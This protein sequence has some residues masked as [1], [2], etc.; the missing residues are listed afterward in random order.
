[1]YTPMAHQL[2]GERFLAN[3]EGFK[4]LHWDMGTGKS[5]AACL[6]LKNIDGPVLILCQAVAL[7]HWQRELEIWL[8]DDPRTVQVIRR[9]KDEITGEII[10]V[11]YS[12][13]VRPITHANLSD[14]G[15]PTV[16]L[17]EIQNLK[18]LSS[19]RTKAVLGYGHFRKYNLVAAAKNIFGLSGT[20]SPN[21][22]SEMYPWL[23]R[24]VPDLVPRTL[25]KFIFKYLTFYNTDWGRTITGNN[26]ATMP[27]LMK[28]LEPVFFRVIKEEVLHD[29]PPM[30]IVDIPIS[31]GGALRKKILDA[32]KELK[33]EILAVLDGAMPSEH[34]ARLRRLTE[35]AKTIGAVEMISQELTDKSYEKIVVFA[36]HRSVI[37]DLANGLEDF[38][39]SVVHGGVTGPARQK[40]I[41]QFQ[42]DDNR[43]FIGQLQA[44]GTSI[45]LHANGRCTN[46]V[47]LS[48]DWVPGNNAQAFA[49]IHRKGQTGNVYVRCLHLA[50]SLDQHV[51]ATLA[52]KTRM[53]EQIFG[54][55]NAAA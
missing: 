30:Q 40:A 3:G 15:F 20:P 25:E 9:S 29:L 48:L 2:D 44:A 33:E 53:L 7:D 41:D 31:N 21:N 47:V 54:D 19:L 5:G 46:A 13:A 24:F 10:I 42:N 27:E 17:D 51:T 14:L 4:M 22:L 38:G 23:K 49:R 32:E 55:N 11:S 37:G 43:V 45:T 16:I 34:V 1:M 8:E 39:V 52:R 26:M 35:M 50:D 36:H 6:A 18:N 28:T 12:T